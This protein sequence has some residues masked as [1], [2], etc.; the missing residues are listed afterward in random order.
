MPFSISEFPAQLK[1]FFKHFSKAKLAVLITL[2]TG[3]LMAFF[4]LIS[5]S[6]KPEFLPIYTNLSA[7]DAG[8]I[9]AYLKEN[10]IPYKLTSSGRVIQIAQ[11]KIYETRIELG[12][13]VFIL[14]C[15]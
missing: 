6:S 13:F 15:A 10:K 11:N 3:S 7:E 5:W 4:L 1:A 12:K 8:E 2:M 9:I 14:L